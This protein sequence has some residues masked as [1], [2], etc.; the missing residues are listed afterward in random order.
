[1]RDLRL[2]PASQADAE[3]LLEWRN[4]AEARAAS[5]N[6]GAIAPPEHAAWLATVL[7]DPERLLLVAELAGEP[8]GQ[9][10]FDRLA[11]GRYEISVGLAPAA[12]G[13]RLSSRLIALGLERLRESHPGAV[14]EAHV[15]HSNARSLAT[16]RRA[17]FR[18][19]SEPAE[20]DFL[21]LLSGGAAPSG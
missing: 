15:R 18:P 20:D 17:G 3:R 9:V 21:V 2:R 7:A 10:R 14:V 1:M 12:R 16:F 4:D 5:R 13:R 8:V 6:S 19:T 11:G